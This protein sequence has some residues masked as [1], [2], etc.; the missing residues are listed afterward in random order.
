MSLLV[1]VQGLSLA[2]SSILESELK[3]TP[4]KQSFLNLD[5]TTDVNNSIPLPRCDKQKGIIS[6]L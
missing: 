1:F 2:E 6:A 3:K 5:P 4:N